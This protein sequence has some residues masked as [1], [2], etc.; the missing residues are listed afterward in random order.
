MTRQNWNPIN[1]VGAK[2]E[3]PGKNR[4]NRLPTIICNYIL[5]WKMERLI[6]YFQILND[7]NLASWLTTFLNDVDG[8]KCEPVVKQKET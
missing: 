8:E 2:Q 1:K 4:K 3:R 5:K 6:Q 7:C